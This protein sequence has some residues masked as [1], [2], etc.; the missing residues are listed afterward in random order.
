MICSGLTAVARDKS[1]GQPR[2]SPAAGVRDISGDDPEELL[3]HLDTEPARLLEPEA[4]D[5]RS[6]AVVL[7]GVV[8][9][10]A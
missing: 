6:G 3:H 10:W 2:S 1:P 4:L 9:S 8:G 7:A 5:K